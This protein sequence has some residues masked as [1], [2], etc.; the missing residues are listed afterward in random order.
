[1]I[2]MSSP[3]IQNTG[4]KHRHTSRGSMPSEQVF[5]VAAV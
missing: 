3:A 1:M 4:A 5:A 2:P